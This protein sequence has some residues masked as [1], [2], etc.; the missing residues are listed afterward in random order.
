[1]RISP[2][3]GMTPYE[4]DRYRRNTNLNLYSA[5]KMRK[6]DCCKRRR[7]VTQFKDKTSKNCFSCLGIKGAK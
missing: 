7:S 3:M 2:V 5:P 4:E 6:C 1:M